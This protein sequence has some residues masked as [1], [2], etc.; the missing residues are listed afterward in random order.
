MEPLLWERGETAIVL[1]A[2]FSRIAS[3]EPHSGSAVKPGFK[4]SA[5]MSQASMEPHSGSAVKQD[6]A[7][8]S[9]PL[10]VAS[11]EPH[12]GSAVKRMER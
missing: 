5:Q 12:S 10:P 3:M 8:A 11:M 7:T 1:L 9:S 4:E 6:T 2:Y